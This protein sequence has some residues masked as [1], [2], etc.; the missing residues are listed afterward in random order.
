MTTLVGIEPRLLQGICLK[1]TQIDITEELN[2]KVLR[3]NQA[4]TVTQLTECTRVLQCTMSHHTMDSCNLTASRPLSPAIT[5]IRPDIVKMLFLQKSCMQRLSTEHTDT[6]TRSVA[7]MPVM[8]SAAWKMKQLRMFYLLTQLTVNTV[9]ASKL[10][11]CEL[12][13]S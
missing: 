6:K 9:A 12:K 5:C 3:S 13:E 11:Q 1:L 2:G 4:W 8:T 10:P 7:A